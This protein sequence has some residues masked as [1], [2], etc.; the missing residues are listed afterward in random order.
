MWGIGPFLKTLKLR[1]L[2]GLASYYRHFVRV[3]GKIAKPLIDLLKKNNFIWTESATVA[4]NN[5]KTTLTTSPILALPGFCK[6]F[7]VETDASGNGIRAV[8]MQHKHPIAFLSKALGPKQWDMSIYEKELLVVVFAIQNWGI[9]L[10]HK[11]FCDKNWS[12]EHEIPPW[13]TA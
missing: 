2:L 3:F 12:K 11:P 13:T 1:G 7:V 10:S 6:T 5:L 8:L 4:F 9:Y